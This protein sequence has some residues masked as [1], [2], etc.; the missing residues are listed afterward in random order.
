MMKKDSTAYAAP[1]PFEDKADCSIRA[2]ACAA[3]TSYEIASMT[4]SAQ[5]RKMKKGTDVNVSIKVH[6]EVLGMK[7]ITL[8]EG[9]RLEAFLEVAKEGRYVVHK[10]GHAFAIVNGIVHDWDNTSRG[11]TTLIRVW[12]VT[13]TTIVKL[14]RVAR[15]LK[16]LT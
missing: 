13:E 2:L 7:R 6:E 12:K 10:K 1:R 14:A 11:A 4:F 5:G 8:A 3:G 9:I 16:E 15:I